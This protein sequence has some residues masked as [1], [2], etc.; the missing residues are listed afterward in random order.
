MRSDKSW[1]LIDRIYE[2]GATG[3]DWA[4]VVTGVAEFV[5]ADTA[6]M[7]VS[8]PELGMASVMAPRSDPA[9]IA[10]YQRHWYV[11]DLTLQATRRSPVGCVTSLKNTGHE[12][13]ARSE[14]YNE[15]WKNSGHARERMAANLVVGTGAV[16]VFGVQPS[17]RAEE[18][19]SGM[20]R[21]F[22]WI[23]PHLVRSVEFRCAHRRLELEREMC[24]TAQFTAVVLVDAEGRIVMSDAMSEKF[25]AEHPEIRIAGSRFGLRNAALSAEVLRHIAS[26]C[27]RQAVP[28]PQHAPPAIETV[29]RTLRIEI[30]PMPVGDTAFRPDHVRYPG[31]LAKLLLSDPSK[32]FGLTEAMLRDELGLTSAEAR[33]A[34]LLVP[35]ETR[36]A[37]AKSLGVSSGTVRTHMIHI[38]QKAGVH[39]R[40][41]LIWKLAQIGS[42]TKD[43]TKCQRLETVQRS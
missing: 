13:F 24:R 16:A 4:G 8:V 18:I 5:G 32:A 35:G 40:A 21:R 28:G 6:W 26:H 9:I 29:D 33:I 43:R 3:H 41:A 30:Q 10:A 34:L 1:R 22:R 31:R 27:R 7:V 20:A 39:S 14:F 2:A 25:M 42:S 37:L 36:E 11:K 23:L 12:A 17:P 19:D 38:F 15:F